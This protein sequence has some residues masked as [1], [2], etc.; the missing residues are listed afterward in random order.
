MQT[1]LFS[2]NRG[3]ALKSSRKNIISLFLDRGWR[4]VLATADDPESRYLCKFGALLEPV[5]FSRGG[6]SPIHDILSVNRLRYIYNKYRPDVVHH[7]HAKP[8]IFG[9]LVA[10]YTLRD[11][12]RVVNTIT[13]LGH[14]FVTGG[15]LSHAAGL[16]YKLSLKNADMTIF[17]NR[18]D[19]KLFGGRGWVAIHKQCLIVGSGV[20]LK[21]F[22]FRT[23]DCGS[24]RQPVVVML[25]RL[26][27]QKGIEEFV[28]VARAVK[29]QC[30][31]AR[32]VWAGELDPVHP[33]AVSETWI[34]RQPDIE[35]AGRLDDVRPLLSSADVLLFP[36]HREGVPRAVM[37]AAAVGLPTVGFRVPGVREAV[38]DDVTGYLLAIGDVS[39]LT[40][41]VLLLL[42]ND[43]LRQEM[44]KNARRMAEKMFDIKSIEQAYFSLYRKLGVSFDDH[45]KAHA[46]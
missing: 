19:Q 16:G 18:D 44:G 36:S 20:D 13:G 42:Q 25:G 17:Q 15:W 7:F 3:Y 1:I 31:Q 12:C 27:K 35:Y 24:A 29:E 45:P 4:V 39:G 33:D 34:N 41:R 2:A 28:S 37:E 9:S 26:L 23:R 46:V 38:E 21:K 22:E 11:S 43:E 10:R 8:V 6:F 5:N 40:A 32:F 14:A 30:P